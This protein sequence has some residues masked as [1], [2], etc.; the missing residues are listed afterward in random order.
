M[1]RKAL[2]IR[3]NLKNTEYLFIGLIVLVVIA[4][5]IMMSV[6]IPAVSGVLSEHADN[7][8]RTALTA[9]SLNIQA[10]FNGKTES[11]KG[12]ANRFMAIDLSNKEAV[13][14]ACIDVAGATGF[15]HIGFTEPNGITISSYGESENT[16]HRAFIKEGLAGRT[17]HYAN[18]NC[19]F[20]DALSD[21]YTVPVRNPKGEIIGTL[22]GD[23]TPFA[24]SEVD[25]M[26]VDGDYTCFYIFDQNGDVVYCDPNNDEGISLGSNIVSMIDDRTVANDVSYFLNSTIDDT[27]KRIKI[28]GKQYITAFSSFTDSDWTIAAIVPEST[29]YA[30]LAP[31]ISFT[32]VLIL[33]MTILLLGAIILVTIKISEI[34]NDIESAIID[35]MKVFYT[36]SITGHDTPAR[37]RENY[38]VA[39]KDTAT[40]HAM[41]SLDVDGFKAINDLFG[42]D[43]GNEVI[44]KMSDSIKRNI[45]KND[46]FTRKSGDL[47]YI[48]ADFSD[49]NE[50]IALADRIISDL[51]YQ[52]NEV[53]LEISVGIY[54]I[55]DPHIKSR[56]AADRS[57]MARETLKNDKQSGYAFFDASMLE[58]LRRQKRIEDIMEDS[59]ALREFI[60]YLQPKYALGD[61]NEVV[62]AEALVRWRHDGRLIPPG[63]F[64]PV[65]EK[66]GF[67]R[68]IDYYMFEE[69]CKLQKKY[70]SM[71]YKPKV[72]SVNM[73]RVHINQPGF[74]SDLAG[75]CDKYGI[76]TKYLEIEITESA[77]YENPVKLYEIFREIK[78]YGFHV[79]ID[80]FGTGYSSLNMLKD[81]PVDVLKI[82]RSFLTENADEHE[83][84]SLIIG[85]VVSL[86][87]S[88]RIHTI[89]EGIETKEQAILLTKLG[90]NM[91]QGF[92]FARPM[93]VADYEEL[94][95]GI[96]AS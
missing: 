86:A 73:S 39:M 64:I 38:A 48:F 24:F 56:V 75:I 94:A 83:N 79:S 71:G 96:K 47:F 33:L 76:E 87:A 36:D 62:G 40:K 6:Y 85:C 41:I 72:I 80:D 29:V 28:G 50:L 57:D 45:G 9:N 95:Y 59:L 11:L 51:E 22:T 77:A 82:D 27:V 26:E 74:V 18:V 55:D 25:L 15:R 4:I 49:K 89:C 30:G 37:F 67:V 20:D 93:P 78:S 52:V 32:V 91:A 88:L 58:K 17:T 81:L 84:A 68:K 46:F 44:K 14:K 61:S 70:L 35:G 3:N 60:V 66:N 69:V 12:F 43:G 23:C 19:D 13:Q 1:E 2:Q 54:V 53:K 90:C 5:I 10:Y 63:D 21:M 34:K 42:Y 8:V 31:I 7:E 92:F 65:F 16:S